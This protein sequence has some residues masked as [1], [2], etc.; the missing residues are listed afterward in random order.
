LERT[1]H[2]VHVACFIPLALTGYV[3]FAP[4]L[5]PLA[6]G[7]AGQFLRILH[8]VTAVFFGLVPIVYTILQPR[9]MLMN[10]REFLTFGKDDAEWLKAAVPYYLAGKHEAMP[11]QP[12]FNTGERLNAV[13]MVLGTLTF[14]ITGLSMWF[15]KDIM[16]V[17]L[18]RLMTIVHDLAFIATFVMFIVHFY[19]AVVHPLM[20]QSL[21]SMRFGYVSESYAR[22]HHA[23]WYYGEERAKEMWE[24]H[25]AEAAH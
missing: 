23:K 9:R 22:E 15:L 12:R 18:F 4:W 1:L 21:I 11:P 5:Q 17:Q 25:K 8:R 2:W 6:Q 13:V 24:Q 16:P 20:W 10:L 19:L 7:E 3:L 14:G